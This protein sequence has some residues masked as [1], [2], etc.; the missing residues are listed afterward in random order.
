MFLLFNYPYSY[1]LVTKCLIFCLIF[2]VIK[3][4]LTVGHQH[5]EGDRTWNQHTFDRPKDGFTQS[6]LVIALQLTEDLKS[7]NHFTVR[8]DKYSHICNLKHRTRACPSWDFIFKHCSLTMTHGCNEVHDDSKRVWGDSNVPQ[9]KNNALFSPQ[10][11]R[12]DDPVIL[13]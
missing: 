6:H 4:Q 11:K 12:G 9:I 10:I 3:T 2:Q 7:C 5:C 1:S 13:K 8:K